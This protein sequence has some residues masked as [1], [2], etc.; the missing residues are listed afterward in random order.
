MKVQSYTTVSSF[1]DAEKANLEA[2]AGYLRA[3]GGRR[4]RLSDG[5]QIAISGDKHI[6]SFESDT[7][8]NLP[9]NIGITL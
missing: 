5:E 2:E 8:L 6:Y 3:T 7:E 1:F 9:D 4:Y